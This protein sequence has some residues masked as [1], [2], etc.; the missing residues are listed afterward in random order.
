M[1]FCLISSSPLY[2]SLLKFTS[3]KLVGIFL[4][5]TPWNIEE[6]GWNLSD[7]C[8]TSECLSAKF[9]TLISVMYLVFFDRKLK[10]I[11]YFT[12]FYFG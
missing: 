11:K 6:Y 3:Y 9:L 12:V 2:R 7:K 4:L 8:N 10:A 1:T 5:S